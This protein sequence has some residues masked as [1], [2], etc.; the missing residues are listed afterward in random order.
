[1]GI[2]SGLFDIGAGIKGRRQGKAVASDYVQAMEGLRGDLPGY[3]APAEFG[4]MGAASMDAATT[5]AATA[6]TAAAQ[7]NMYGAGDARGQAE[8]LY[9]GYS[10]ADVRDASYASMNQNAADAINMAGGRT[11]DRQ[12]AAGRVATAMA[13]GIE[14][15]YAQAQQNLAMA[16][17]AA[18][19]NIMGMGTGVS[20]GN[21]GAQNQRDMF[22]Q[23]QIQQANLANIGNQQQAN[24]FNAGN[25]QQAN[26]FNVGG[27]NQFNQTQA[28]KNYLA[29]MNQYQQ[30]A[31]NL[32][33]Q[34]GAKTGNIQNMNQMMQQIGQGGQGVLDQAGQIA[35]STGTGF[36]KLAPP[37]PPVA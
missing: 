2:I 5:G 18:G 26:M 16:Q 9:G 1:M 6:P 8:Q 36:G 19:Q 13:P 21:V 28:D 4:T 25:Q 7:A 11:Q 10:P 30:N 31:G 34:Y 33:A 37:I 20:Q 24:M 35:A 14:N 29:A 17:G 23:Q 15:Q 27:Q 32:G 12:R 22:N 3:N